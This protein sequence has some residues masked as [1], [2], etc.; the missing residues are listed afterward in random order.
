MVVR[1]ALLD[2]NAAS[3]KTLAKA[4]Q[5]EVEAQGSRA[6][7]AAF[8]HM[9]KFLRFFREKGGADAAFLDILLPDGNGVE[10]A[11]AIQA[12][13]PLTKVVFFSAVAANAAD[14][15]EACPTYFLTKPIDPQKLSL[16]VRAVLA[17]L[18]RD[19]SDVVR[20]GGKGH[21]HSLRRSRIEYVESDGRLLVFHTT[22]SPVS[23][24]GRME[25]ILRE[26]GPGFFRCH[27]SYIV[28]LRYIQHL[29]RQEF[30]FFSGSRLPIS[31]KRLADAKRA[32]FSYVGDSLAPADRPE[33]P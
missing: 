1:I 6:E 30:V 27:K 24:Y 14:I 3:L 31:R 4:V 7:I 17:S 33:I 22:E 29:D 15:F 8:Q 32:F 5:A 12:S 23:V 10:A 26:L 25:D 19:L 20:L 9:D 28:N 21:A 13:H 18:E 11:K 16:A 2:D